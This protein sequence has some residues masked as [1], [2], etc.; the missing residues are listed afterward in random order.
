MLFRSAKQ[1]RRRAFLAAAVLHGLYDFLLVG[2][3]AFF[4]LYFIF[5]LVWVLRLLRRS[6]KEDRPIE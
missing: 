6:A 5:L 1:L 4:Y 2:F 3:G